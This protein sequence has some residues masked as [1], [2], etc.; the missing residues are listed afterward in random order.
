MNAFAQEPAQI[1]ESL[2]KNLI[3]QDAANDN[4]GF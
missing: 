4:N 1:S 2:A 3:V